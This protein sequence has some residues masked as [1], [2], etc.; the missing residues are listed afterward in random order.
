MTP[1]KV[2]LQ[3]VDSTNAYLNRMLKKGTDGRILVVRADY[4]AHG[5][6]Q[7][8]HHWDSE[9]GKNLL[10]SFL[11]YPEF[12]S[13]S[14]QFQL[15]MMTSVALCRLLNGIGM[16]TWIKWPNDI[17]VFSGKKIAGILIEIGVMGKKLT[18]SIIGI[19]LNLNQASFPD[20]PR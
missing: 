3:Q 16:Q 11:L 1:W 2:H 4:Q 5:K 20:F 13:A 10:M 14:T 19:G 18:H 8:A 9:A 12:L 17:L 7:G 6:G 15:S